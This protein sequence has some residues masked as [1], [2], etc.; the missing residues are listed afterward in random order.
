MKKRIVCILMMAL[1]AALTGCSQKGSEEEVSRETE[2]KKDR[3][4]ITVAIWNA[5][6]ALAG[7]AVLDAIEE[8]FGVEFEPYNMTWNDYY[9]K[10]ERWAATDSLPD[11][12]IG[13]FRNSLLYP[14][15]IQQGVLCAIPDDL[16]AYPNLKSYVDGLEEIQLSSVD[17]TLYCIPRQTY[18]SQEWTSIDRIVIYRWDLAQKAGITKEPENWEEFQEMILAIIREDPEVKGIQGMTVGNTGI[19]TGLLLPYASSIAA[20][21]GNDFY[22][23][24][25]SDG[26]YKPVYF[27]DDMTC[28]FQLG[29]DM[30]T[31]GVIEKTVIQQTTNSAREKFLQGEN[32]AILYSGGMSNIYGEVGIY[33][34]EFHDSSFQEDVKALKL[35]PDVNGQ[36][37]YPIWGYAWCESYISAKVDAEKL[38]KILRIYDYLLSDEG[39]F[40]AAYG[41]E[42]EF[43]KVVDGRAELYDPGVDVT[44]RYPSCKLL[45]VLVRWDPSLYDERFPSMVP[46]EYLEVN[47]ELLREA[48]EVPI[49]EY[50]PECGLIMKEEQIDFSL[51]LNN[52]FLSIMTGTEPVEEMWEEIRNEYEEKG[53]QDMIDIVNDRLQRQSE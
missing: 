31:S 26:V 19:L 33:W 37:T 14:K 24:K 25:D 13:D 49:P 48:K 52:D 23:K 47:Y 42:G 9:Q 27:V 30:Y 12:F 38:D 16:S 40:F 32:A 46:D 18:P 22:W 8:R 29:R 4:K 36:K 6:E 41:P 34:K 20:G 15:W 2:D 28:A 50:E 11:L 39:A 10:V 51:D 5:E 53:L 1:L 17:G 45:S 21:N 35:M 3:M 43:Y 7:D 44:G